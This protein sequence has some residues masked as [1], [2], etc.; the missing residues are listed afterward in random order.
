[1]QQDKQIIQAEIAVKMK[2][3]TKLKKIVKG[4]VNK[5]YTK[6]GNSNCK[7]AKGEKHPAFQL[8]YK[9]ENNLTKTIYLSKNKVNMTLERIE[10]Y[11]LAR[12]LFNEIVELNIELLKFEKM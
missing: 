10:N 7:C 5:V 1:M 6:C 3:L 12:K 9:A 4:T 11:K 8:T 2:Q